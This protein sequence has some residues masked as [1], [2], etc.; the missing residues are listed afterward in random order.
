M[1]QLTVL[2]APINAV[3]HVNACLGA[4]EAF[5]QRGHRVIFLVDA[6]FQGKAT[7][8][9]YEEHIMVYPKDNDEEESSKEENPGER[10]GQQL[11]ESKV[12]G[13]WSVEEKMVN[14]VKMMHGEK[15]YCDTAAYDAA[16]R[17]CLE[18]YRP[19][20]VYI[21]H[22]FLPPSVHLSETPWVL[23][24]SA[25]PACYL[26]YDEEDDCP[27]GGSGKRGLLLMISF[28]VLKELLFVYP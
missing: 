25:V 7:A 23:N 16:I 3:G 9:G 18:L 6:V 20:L 21:D 2:V 28:K 27:P 14:C 5:P 15:M 4:L 11:V 13:P 12:I 22:M 10:I 1:K 19:D 8:R 17:Q 26:D 24:A